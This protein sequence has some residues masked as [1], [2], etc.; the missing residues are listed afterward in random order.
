MIEYRQLEAMAAVASAKSFEKGAARLNITQS[1]I[2]QRI[3]LLEDSLGTPVLIRTTPPELTSMGQV[4]MNH[5]QKVC[6]LEDELQQQIRPDQGKIGGHLP[7]AINRDSLGLWFMEAVGG[8]LKKT[9][10]ILQIFAE[11]QEQTHHHLK[12]G[13]VFACVSTRKKAL[14]GCKVSL[15]GS[16]HFYLCASPDYCKK[17]FT[18][19]VTTD[20]LLE[21]PAVVFDD[22]DHMLNDFMRDHYNILDMPLTHQ[23]PALSEYEKFII[24]GYAYG[25]LA[26]AQVE[27]RFLEKTLVDI[28]PGK[29]MTLD[30]YWHTWQLETELTKR[31]TSELLA[32]SKGLIR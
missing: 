32:N 14:Q 28:A 9:N 29:R 18:G 16:M 7:I 3:K 19:K 23:V 15:L 30:L 2:S 11:D 12:N 25:L 26:T 5:Y 13:T 8:F 10:T 20:K 4:M 27:K 21:A 31:F 17:W 6:L 1:A 24:D 22:K